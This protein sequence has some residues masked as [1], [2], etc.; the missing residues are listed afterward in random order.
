MLHLW[1]ARDRR[2]SLEEDFELQVSSPGLTEPFKVKQQYIKNIG[3]QIQVQ[4][5]SG[6]KLEG[7]L[8]EANND[9]LKLETEKRE[10]VEGHKKKQ[11]IRKKYNF[12][13]NEIKSAKAVISFK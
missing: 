6:E 4:P 5:N 2:K 7:K 3:R 9:G 8:L 12:N 13:Y 10:R 1:Y 11:L